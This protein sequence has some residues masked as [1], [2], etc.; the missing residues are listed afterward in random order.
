MTTNDFYE[1][2]V[3]VAVMN[4]QILHVVL[5]EPLKSYQNVL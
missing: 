2:K 3:F 1:L 5:E 4:G